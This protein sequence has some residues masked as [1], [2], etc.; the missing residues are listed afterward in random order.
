MYFDPLY[1]AVLGIGFLLSA[2]AS[3]WTKAAFRKY[4]RV[5]TSGGRTGADIAAAILR[6]EGVTGVRIEQVGG[7]LSDHYDPRSRTLRLSPGVY[8]ER[9]VA[10]AGIAAHEVGHALQHAQGYLPMRLRQTMVPV[11]NIGTNVGLWITIIGMMVGVSGIALIGVI[12][13][14]GFVA[15]TV[16]TLPV[17]FDA[18]FRARRA[19]ERHGLLGPAELAGVSRILTAAAATYLAA[20]AAAILQL[21]YWLNR[22]GLLG[23]RR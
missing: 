17:E 14:G 10:A 11:A 4:A 12:L 16:V 19:L 20:A 21:L 6:A 8:G 18:S 22:L 2:G 23:G 7:F 3:M 5:P 9:S 1:M 13:F 15:F